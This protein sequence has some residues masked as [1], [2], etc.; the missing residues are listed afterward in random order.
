[1]KERTLDTHSSGLMT[2]TWYPSL[3][4]TRRR[5]FGIFCWERRTV[6]TDCSALRSVVIT[7]VGAAM[8]GKTLSILSAS[9]TFA[10]PTLVCGLVEPI[11]AFQYSTI[12][13]DADVP[14]L[15]CWEIAEGAE[16]GIF[17]STRVTG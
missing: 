5:E 17:E 16:N 2:A 8:R 11:R 13:L 10:M 9:S 14:S 7:N 4:S 3:G 6:S 1:M 12:S 15:L